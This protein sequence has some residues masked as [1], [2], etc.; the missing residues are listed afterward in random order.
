MR[1]LAA[2][3]AVFALAVPLAAE[4]YLVEDLNT[5]PNLQQ[6]RVGL[7]TAAD[8]NV[9]YFS[10]S[11]PAHGLE[12]W[13]TDGTPDGTWRLT[14][15]C[16]GRCDAAPTPVAILQGRVFFGA[17]DGVSG[18]ELWQSDGTPGSERR[19]RDICPGP[20]SGDP[21]ALTVLGDRL[22]FAASVGPHRSLWSSD[23]TRAGTVPLQEICN[24]AELGPFAGGDCPWVPGLEK[25][26][27]LV[28]FGVP[29]PQ[30]GGFD[31]WRSDGTP[32]G[33]RSLLDLVGSGVGI[34]SDSV[35]YSF[36]R[37][38]GGVGLL[39]TYDALWRTD[40]T[41]EGTFRLASVADLTADGSTSS[42]PFRTAVSNGLLF[43]ILEDGELIRSDGT[44][45]GTD[46]IAKFSWG[47]DVVE[48][49]PTASGLLFLVTTEGSEGLW[50]SQGTA[51]TTERL[52]GIAEGRVI[53]DLAPFGDR[54]LFFA[55]PLDESPTELWVT[56]GTPAGT[57]LLLDDAGSF[58]EYRGLIAVGTRG[59]FG[60]GSDYT[61]RELWTT[62][63]TPAGTV[64][65]RDFGSGPGSS[66]P[67]DQAV[68]NGRLVFSAQVSREEAP[69]FESDGT[70]AGTR[71]LS[72]E[73]SRA[74]GFTQAGDRL[75]FAA[76]INGTSSTL[77]W[78]DGAS[79][80][81]NAPKA[82][83][84][85]SFMPLGSTLLFGAT[86][87]SVFGSSDVEL[88]RSDGAAKGTRMVKNIDPASIYTGFHQTCIGESSDPGPG[89]EIRGRLI[90]AAEDGRNGRELWIS[91]GTRAGTRLLRDIR[92]GKAP[93]EGDQCDNRTEKGLSSSPDEFLVFRGG[94]LFAADDGT[95][96]RELWWTDGTEA[97][98]R[99][100]KDL[101][102]GAEGSNPHDLTFFHGKVYFFARRGTAGE[103]LWRTDGTRA[104]TV[105]VDALTLAGTPSWPRDLTLVGERMFFSAYNERI[106]AELWTSRGTA[107]TTAL[108]TDLRRGTP[109]SS[110]Q[111]LTAVGDILLFA[112]DDGE[113][114]LEPWRSDG[115]AEGTR[116]VADINPGRD[117]SSPGPYSRVDDLL[118]TGADDGEHG[119]ELWAIP[120]ED[121]IEP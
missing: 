35:W 81:G 68:F 67:L 119:R 14:D 94:A 98:T 43:T 56:D 84:P 71:E 33:T 15:V 1:L 66:G 24:L 9:A 22:L 105:P 65:L 106:G 38:V 52:S 91:D 41:P 97:G 102:P 108:V 114:G 101:L 116:R 39:W 117:A 88:W 57:H 121:V 12:L 103:A 107:A 19:V 6:P 92:P 54:A 120:V 78:L 17:D 31:I 115:T 80:L 83:E 109:S 25:V 61:T 29:L 30:G 111:A 20:C 72:D 110:P 11:D 48:L 89:V 16:P 112:A 96:G 26:G 62:N 55:S 28:F 3:F 60:R 10:A 87:G 18:R 2:A 59:Y 74:S 58:H 73:A 45:E 95:A 76:S 4:P 70:P 79:R 34:S 23:G 49:T 93:W 27:G 82:L 46:R 90:F 44:P 85:R 36:V 100:V 13:R 51:E 7:P 104:G 50:R 86:I 8:G 113:H 75:Y 42:Y 5:G 47:Y 21:S 32:E 37:D 63:G 53:T 40:G 64:R 118:L 69:L 77:W 99:R